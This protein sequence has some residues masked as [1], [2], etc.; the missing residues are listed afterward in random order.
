MLL[1]S[2]LRGIP[3]VG[4]DFESPLRS[5]GSPPPICLSQFLPLEGGALD[6]VSLL[7]LSFHLPTSSCCRFWFFKLLILVGITVGAFYI[8]D[9]SFS[10]S[11]QAGGGCGQGGGCGG[12][13]W[14][15]HTQTLGCWLLPGL[16]AT[17][18]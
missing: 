16:P 14:L 2:A 15:W 17:V 6:F 10:N 5:S 4:T 9:G 11:R 13:S 7:P 12:N 1:P 18:G 3:K 8:P